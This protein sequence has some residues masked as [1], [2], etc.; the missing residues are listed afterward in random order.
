LVRALRH[1]AA[2]AAAVLLSAAAHAE[3]VRRSNLPAGEATPI[4]ASFSVHMPV[5]YS[6]EELQATDPANPA[7]VRM[8]TGT[9]D[10][11]IKFSAS[12]TPFLP[13]AERPPLEDFM[14]ALKENPFVAALV[15]V[16]HEK[17]AGRETLTFTLVDIAAG[18]NFFDVVRTDQAQYMLTVQF[19]R[20]QR[21]E[22]VAM[23]GDF[24]NSFKLRGQ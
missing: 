4:G 18:G 14:K 7:I 13:G 11:G 15:D 5:A 22:A 17:S 6:D 20:A 21:D 24:F 2:I 3:T 1:A 12:E 10:D 8:V 23:K 9:T 16:R 19:H